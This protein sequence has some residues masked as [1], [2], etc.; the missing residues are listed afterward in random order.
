VYVLC[1]GVCE[2]L[3]LREHVGWSYGHRMQGSK[4][5]NVIRTWHSRPMNPL[6]RT[7]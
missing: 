5:R 6:A 7:M 1:H 3:E 2:M 4:D